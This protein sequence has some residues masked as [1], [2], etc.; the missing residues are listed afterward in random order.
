M[1]HHHA[2]FGPAV[3]SFSPGKAPEDTGL[4]QGYVGT[5]PETSVLLLFGI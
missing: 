4:A 1:R 5:P 3:T 2:T